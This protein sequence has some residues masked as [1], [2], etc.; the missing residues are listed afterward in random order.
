M[1]DSGKLIVLSTAADRSKGR[2]VQIFDMR[3]MARG[4]I[5]AKKL[6]SYDFGAIDM[7]YEE[8]AGAAGEGML[9]IINRGFDFCQ[10]FSFSQG[11]T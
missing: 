1:G 5:F 9:F 3:S 6:D 10:F 2:G 4:P 11:Q 8:P 7:H